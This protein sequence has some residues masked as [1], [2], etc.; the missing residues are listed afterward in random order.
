MFAF[1][2]TVDEP[3]HELER[4]SATNNWSYR[5]RN[6]DE[7]VGT[8]HGSNKLAK[9][10]YYFH[11][12]DKY[13]GAFI[14]Y[15]WQMRSV[16]HDS[17]AE[18]H[19]RN[20]CVYKGA[21]RHDDVQNE[22]YPSQMLENIADFDLY[23][24]QSNSRLY[25]P[26]GTCALFCSFFPAHNTLSTCVM[27]YPNGEKYFGGL[28]RHRAREGMGF[29]FY[30]NGDEYAGEWREDVMEGKGTYFFAPGNRLSKHT[31]VWKRGKPSTS[32]GLLVYPNGDVYEGET[33]STGL[34]QGRGTFSVK[35]SGEKFVGEFNEDEPVVAPTSWSSSALQSS[36]YK[37]NMLQVCLCFVC[38]LYIYLYSALV[39]SK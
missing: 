2:S 34:K 38:V 37:N 25:F 4:V 10:T 31:S 13:V 30:A 33:T 9:G 1:Q 26:D 14:E 8:F 23:A 5:F 16:K 36:A 39:N 17:R 19:F 21:F 6:G 32:Y 3:I 28:N 35:S 7:F 20:G 12:G 15:G 22:H 29:Y 27:I 24:R 11:N 18:Y